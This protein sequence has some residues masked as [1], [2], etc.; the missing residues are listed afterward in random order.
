MKIY[1][2]F[3]HKLPPGIKRHWAHKKFPFCYNLSTSKPY[4][5]ASTRITNTQ[6][7]AMQQL[8]LQSCIREVE[9]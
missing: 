7:M 1:L 6:I 4:R 2:Q 3:A 8:T 9:S 5:V